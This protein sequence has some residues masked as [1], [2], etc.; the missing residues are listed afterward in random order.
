VRLAFTSGLVR[1]SEDAA[2]AAGVP[3]ASLMARAGAAVAAEASAF[4]PEGA[5]LV[6]TGRGNNG[7]DGWVAAKS[8]LESGRAVSVLSLAPPDALA[9]H[10]ADAARA[11]V[12]AGVPW[13]EAGTSAEIV[14]GLAEADLIIDAVFGVGLKDAPR[15]PSGDVLAA[16]DDADA[17][18]LSIDVPSG[19]DADTGAVP[20]AAVHADVTVTFHSP[21]AGLILYP[22]ADLAGEIVVAD[23]GLPEPVDLGGA[24]EV[25]DFADLAFLL[26]VPTSLDHK[27]TRG[28]VLVIGGSPGLTGAVCLTSMGSLKMGAGYVTAAVPEPS[29]AVVECK[30]TA[31]VKVGLPANAEGWL[32]GP[33]VERVIHLAERADAVVLGPGLG[34]SAETAACVRALACKLGKPL[35][36]DADGLHALGDDLAPLKARGASTV[37]TPHTGEAA[38]LLG[39]SREAVEIDR[40]AAARAIGGSGVVCVLKGARTLVSDGERV[41]ATMAGGPGLATLGT[42]DVLAGMIGTLLAQGLDPLDAAVL[43]AHLHGA[44]GDVAAR[45]LTPVCCTA[46]DVLTYLHEAVRELI[47]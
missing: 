12:G 10:A 46:E 31:P 11:A 40:P 35:L 42:G 21:K 25:W 24:L 29:L 13:R 18:V 32:G 4:M 33:A 2:V 14:L 45:Q 20:G 44:A 37:V 7:G 17:P 6:V 34:R 47:A 30:L 38:R 15:G 26:P 3:L 36:L 41:V 8:L 39:I 23:I 9:A 27:G 28:A 19:V 22:G 5:I 16:M 1:R 43:G